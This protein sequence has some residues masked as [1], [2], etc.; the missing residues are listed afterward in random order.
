MAI[1]I[2]EGNLFTTQCQT[3]VNTINCVGVMGAGIAL[4]CRLRYP[5]MFETYSKLCAEKRFR[6]GVL[7]LYKGGLDDRDIDN[8][9]VLNFPTKVHWK[10]PSKIEWVEAGLEKFLATY[11]AKGIS[12]VAFPVLG[13]LNGGL[14][15]EEVVSLMCSKLANSEIPL[16]IYHYKADAADD[17]FERFKYLL[18]S[19]TAEKIAE[20]SGLR[21]DYV[22]RINAAI[23]NST[24]CQLNQLV[25]V[26]GIG[27]KTLEKVFSLLRPG[28]VTQLEF[29]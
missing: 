28:N 5:A 20:L 17:L 4:E 29:L 13:G 6:P 7:W 25:G 19:K 8:K 24:I 12:S 10:F 16:E 21:I 26:N 9:W 11:K 23:D 27:A 14:D 2:I 22:R 3:I 15:P 1:K 18:K